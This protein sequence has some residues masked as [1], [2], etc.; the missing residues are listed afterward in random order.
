VVSPLVASRMLG[1]CMTHIYAWMKS[2]E[3]VS[4]RYG[5]SRRIV[6]QSIHDLIARRI[7][8]DKAGWQPINAQ[9]PQDWRQE[10]RAKL[11]AATSQRRRARDDQQELIAD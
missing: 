7:A 1:A 3:L 5:R 10:K 11:E 8:A 6:V 4:Y 2:G 9:P